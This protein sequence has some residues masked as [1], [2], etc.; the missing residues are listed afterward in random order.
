MCNINTGWECANGT[1]TNP[2]DCIEICGDG[3]DYF[4]YDCDDGNDVD[5]DGCDSS[6][7]LEHPD[8][9]CQYGDFPFPD[10]CTFPCIV[11]SA[12]YGLLPCIDNN[13]APLDG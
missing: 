9:L 1:N 6:C 7:N 8:F 13:N 10:I 4:S 5:G 12:D 11:T 2:D 3:Y